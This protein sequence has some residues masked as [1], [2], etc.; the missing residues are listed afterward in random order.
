MTLVYRMPYEGCKLRYMPVLLARTVAN[1]LSCQ[2][3]A[4]GFIIT[5]SFLLCCIL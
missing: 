3:A 2:I 1:P 5:V 4:V